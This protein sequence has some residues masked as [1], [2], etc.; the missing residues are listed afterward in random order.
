MPIYK[1]PVQS[2]QTKEWIGNRDR[3]HW[4]PLKSL[5]RQQRG[6]GGSG[7]GS[8]RDQ[9]KSGNDCG[10]ITQVINQS[11]QKLS[12]AAQGVVED[13]PVMYTVAK[14]ELYLPT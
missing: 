3:D 9:E 12:Q 8:D 6:E 4:V 7:A 13:D 1:K 2:D 14:V 10:K 11:I 5:P